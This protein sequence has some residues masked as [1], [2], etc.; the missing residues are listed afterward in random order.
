[1]VSETVDEQYVKRLKRRLNSTKKKNKDLILINKILMGI[2]VLFF[3]ITGFGIYES[4]G[5]QSKLQEAKANVSEMEIQVSNTNDKIKDI[6]TEYCTAY[7]ENENMKA[8]ITSLNKTLDD[9]NNTIEEQNKK[10]ADYSEK[11][12]IKENYNYA[13]YTANGAKTDISLDQIQHL[14]D[15]AKSLGMTDDS[16]DVVLAIALH[17]SSGQAKVKN[18]TSTAAGLCGILNGTGK[19]VYT[20]VM[21]KSGYDYSMLF[22]GTTNMD[23]SLNYLNYLSKSNNNNTVKTLTSYRGFSDDSFISFL[24][25]YLGKKGKSVSSIK[26]IN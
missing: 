21:K 12:D 2:I 3:G 20:D 8:E 22:D 18:P 16:V 13:L 17:E 25:K 5:L 23:I 4:L 26:I 24:N 6:F 15:E 1:M 11:L 14:K 19:F 9:S 10:L 7:E